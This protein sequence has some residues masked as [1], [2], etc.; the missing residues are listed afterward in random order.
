MA[1]RKQIAANRKNALQSTGPKTSNGKAVAKMNP[2]KHGILAR[3]VVLQGQHH[4]EQVEEFRQLHQ[5]YWQYLAPVGPVEEMLVE[6]IVTT[7]WRLQRVLIAERGE[8]ARSVDGQ[9][10]QCHRPGRFTDKFRTAFMSPLPGADLRME[11]SF[12][13]LCYLQ[14]VLSNV[15]ACVQQT[16]ELTDDALEE[17]HL[18]RKQTVLTIQLQQLRAAPV[19][20]AAGLDDAA[21]KTLRQATML[22]E[23]DR[24]LAEYDRQKVVCFERE[25]AEEHASLDAA[26]LPGAETLEKIMR[27]ETTLERQ[28]YRA[29]NQLERLQRMRRGEPIPSPV[30]MEVGHDA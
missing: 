16:G 4:D 17:T 10:W 11:E 3:H 14:S 5:H 29:M 15:R 25:R 19:E 8:I 7:Y 28:L 6:R 22:K 13:G 9:H 2:V 30:L 26:H 18:G 12:A 21:V 27:Y 20:N 1:T 23:I 24:M